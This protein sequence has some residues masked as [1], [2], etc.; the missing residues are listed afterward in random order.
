VRANARCSGSGG[1]ISGDGGLIY[2][3]ERDRRHKTNGVRL[4]VI[5]YRLKDVEPSAT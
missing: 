1:V 5:D 4:R 3:T 2:P